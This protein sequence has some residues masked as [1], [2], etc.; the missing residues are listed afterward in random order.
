[1]D[2][3]IIKKRA[4][5]VVS[6][7]VLLVVVLIVGYVYTSLKWSYSKGERVGYVQKFS[8][9]GWV[10]KTWEGEMQMLPI[11][12]SMPEKF[13]FSVRDNAVVTKLNS[14][15]GKKV[16]II[17]EQHKGLPA[18]CFGESEYFITDCKPLE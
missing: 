2:S 14:S 11:P 16:G 10:N 3:A 13:L 18:K 8:E 6:I 1:M 12:G 15:L 17:Y 9:K 7:L 5:K 4:I